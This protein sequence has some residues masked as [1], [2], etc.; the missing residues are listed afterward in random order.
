MIERLS[1]SQAAFSQAAVSKAL[2]IFGMFMPK[3][4][5][6][7]FLGTTLTVALGG[8]ATA[9]VCWATSS[10]R[11]PDPVSGERATEKNKST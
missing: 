2:V 6:V 11:S 10:A 8:A 3:F 9:G 5:L 1:A 7:P 4:G